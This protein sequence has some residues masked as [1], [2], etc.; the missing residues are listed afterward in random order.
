MRRLNPHDLAK[1]HEELAR[2]VEIVE[3][4]RQQQGQ[5]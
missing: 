3:R 2:A 5:T 4:R 1:H